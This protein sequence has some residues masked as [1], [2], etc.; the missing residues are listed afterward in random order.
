M[1]KINI[2]LGSHGSGKSTFI[3]KKIFN[4]AYGNDSKLDFSKKIFLI[5]PE[6]DN[7]MKQKEIINFEDNIGKG[8]LNIDCISFDR[9]CYLVFENTGEKYKYAND[10]LKVLIIRLAINELKKEK[11]NFKY[12]DFTHDNIGVYVKIKSALSE[13]SNYGINEKALENLW[14]KINSKNSAEKINIREKN[15]IEDLK[16]IQKKYYEILDRNGYKISEEKLS[17]LDEDRLKIIFNDSYCFFDGFTGFTPLQKD[18]FFKMLNCIKEAYIS[19]DIRINDKIKN[20]IDKYDGNGFIIE[21]N[22]IF[23]LSVDYIKTIEKIRQDRNIKE[24]IDFL[25]P[26]KDKNGECIKYIQEDFIAIE[27]NIFN[28]NK[29]FGNNV[30]LENIV[31]FKALDV[32][33]EVE[34]VANEIIKL[35]KSNNNLS[36]EDI[37][38]VTPDINMY[39]NVIMDTFRKK[40]IPLFIDDKKDI[41]DSPLISSVKNLLIVL[42]NNFMNDSVMKYIKSGLY[43]FND[44]LFRMDNLAKEYNLYNLDTWEKRLK[45]V[46]N[47]GGK[48]NNKIKIDK[49][50]DLQDEI[51][52]PLIEAKD[53]IINNENTI[54]TYVDMIRSYLKNESILK[55]YNYFMMSINDNEE[56]DN[57]TKKMLSDNIEILNTICDKLNIINDNENKI[58]IDVFND[59]FNLCLESIS[60][61]TIPMQLNQVVAGD[62]IR[63]RY[64]NPKILF[65]MGMNE[66]LLPPEADDS[67]IINDYIREIFENNNYQLSFTNFKNTINTK[68]YTY[69]AVTS[70]T[71]K[72]YLS[73][74]EINSK[75]HTDYKSF[76]FN[77]IENIFRANKDNNIE[78]NLEPS[79]RILYSINEAIEY[80]RINENEKLGENDRKKINEIKELIKDDKFS[81][82]KVDSVNKE[83]IN[84]LFDNNNQSE[85]EISATG[86]EAYVGCPFK[87]FAEKLLNI[88][89]R[90]EFTIDSNLLGNVNHNIMQKID[91]IKSEKNNKQIY[92]LISDIDN[93][94]YIDNN[95]LDE[96]FN[97]TKINKY[98]LNKD[99]LLIILKSLNDD[100]M[101]RKDV[102]EYNTISFDIDRGMISI[103]SLNALINDTIRI[104]MFAHNKSLLEDIVF[105]LI[106]DK[107]FYK[108]IKL[109]NNIYIKEELLIELKSYLNNLL[110]NE[111]NN[112]E[113]KLHLTNLIDNI[114]EVYYILKNFLVVCAS[115]LSGKRG[116]GY[117]EVFSKYSNV[118][119]SIVRVYKEYGA[120][121]IDEFMDELRR[122]LIDI[123]NIKNKNVNNSIIKVVDDLISD[124][125]YIN[126]N[127]DLNNI[128]SIDYK[129]DRK[130]KDS[131][132]GEYLLVRTKEVLSKTLYNLVINDIYRMD[133]IF[134]KVEY[135]INKYKIEYDN[136]IGEGKEL[137][138]K[139]L[140]NGRI[141][142]FIVGSNNNDIYI[143]IVDYKSRNK[144]VSLND[145]KTGKDLRNI[146]TLIYLSY[147]LE[148][149]DLK[150]MI[151]ENNNKIIDK[152]T[153]IIPVGSFYQGIIDEYEYNDN[154]DEI[155]N[156]NSNLYKM[157]GVLNKD[158]LKVF[159]KGLD[160]INTDEIK[161]Y[162][163]KTYS[164]GDSKS[165]NVISE[166][167]FEESIKLL[168]NH[169]V[170]KV[171]E[172][173]NG[174]IA[175]MPYKASMSS[176]C[177]YCNLKSLCK[178]EEKFNIEDDENE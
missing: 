147:L 92:D 176:T 153:K 145:I 178:R 151:I 104:L 107:D 109:L 111:F 27:K 113:E 7:F 28:E 57:V 46:K 64:N 149:D 12:F 62:L 33:N 148:N 36:F 138:L 117:A 105:V 168:K 20:A 123:K 76:Y 152:D 112:D 159:E 141:D 13:F 135:E 23:N 35:I 160:F 140:L 42:K 85:M 41:L 146:Q 66:S 91:E 1:S 128:N 170:E 165:K 25:Y 177:N 31:F 171:N 44:E 37:K 71:E 60:Y 155:L 120:S 142:K 39:K 2:V 126:D 29:A 163:I 53:K 122:I 103:I 22:D 34:Q 51:L 89:K 124:M 59:L 108:K 118:D 14:N 83:T 169:I 86:I 173:K 157:T 81:D 16:I 55:R 143:E 100:C 26:V 15:K 24:K 9:L 115:S 58:T 38:I 98:N 101:N 88:Y 19:I 11:V 127:T 54:N 45:L 154:E 70:P 65:F 77:E 97:N 40:N 61:K 96:Y 132:L 166:E 95:F 158:A 139:V 3:N 48:N 69:L 133:S 6:Q 50:I 21:E 5:V 116:K 156:Y 82:V 94:K 30:K 130:F 79:E 87:Y 73:Y 167:E 164:E 150:K 110:E 78:T 4:L 144:T 84:L 47:I 93:N 106:K 43:S 162:N 67:N 174:N 136:S 131:K 18:T 68:Y 175:P 10:D 63:S 137:D 72:L 56:I 90:D 114:D 74:S 129:N 80:V 102:M 17:L 172:I 75:G 125:F 119:Y 52:K 134:S 32:R 161:N 99:K 121:D 8:I 49:I